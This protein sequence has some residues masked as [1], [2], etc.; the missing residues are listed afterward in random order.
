MAYC[1]KLQRHQEKLRLIPLLLKLELSLEQI[2][3]EL[4]WELEEV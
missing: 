3:Q 2:A 1:A 4:N